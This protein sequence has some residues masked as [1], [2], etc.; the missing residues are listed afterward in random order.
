MKK[1]DFI[2]CLLI[3]IIALLIILNSGCTPDGTTLPEPAEPEEGRREE[4]LPDEPTLDH[5]GWTK[6]EI[7]DLFGLPDDIGPHGGPGGEELYYES[8]AVTFILAGDEGI[9][10][11]LFLHPGSEM[12]GIRLG[13]MH[14]DEIEEILG[15][16]IFRG[17]DEADYTYM[18]LYDISDKTDGLNNVELFI[19]AE[20]DSEIA[21]GMVVAWKGYWN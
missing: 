6:E 15:E 4:D 20:D 9:V 19:T 17:L 2:K 5:L 16:P 11:N 18:M 12:L 3:L 13:E 1:G 14:F 8:M 21:T 7:L 10:N